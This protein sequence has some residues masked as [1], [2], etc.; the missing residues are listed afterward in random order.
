MGAFVDYRFWLE[1][2]EA[3][4]SMEFANINDDH[5]NFVIIYLIAAT[6]LL[7][8]FFLTNFYDNLTHININQIKTDESKDSERENKI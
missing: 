5:V 6:S 1:Q 4:Q 2:Y 7:A 3:L 8:L